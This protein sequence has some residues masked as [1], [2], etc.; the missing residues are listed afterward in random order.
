M[1]DKERS[2]V[3]Y[4]KPIRLLLE[5]IAQTRGMTNAY[6]QGDENFKRKIVTKRAEV[7]EVFKQLLAIDKEIG[8]SLR[9]GKNV[10]LLQ[11]RWSDISQRAF[12]GIAGSIFA[13]Y[14][15]LI[16]DSIDF[17]DTIARQGGLS[18]EVDPA[19][20]YMV[21]IIIHTLPQQIESLGKL[22]GK[23]AGMIAARTY[24]V[25]DK[26]VIASLASAKHSLSLKKDLDYS[27]SMDSALS[28][29]LQSPFDAAAN[30]FPNC[31]NSW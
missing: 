1:V 22:R 17:L 12:T 5:N 30:E 28:E 23:G 14:S 9:S 25:A 7:D 29:V 31:H 10:S 26:I 18:T 13:E 4:I 3:R 27:I 11:K 16:A 15:L 6:L 19:N 24:Q 2:A 21:N 8:Q 20:N